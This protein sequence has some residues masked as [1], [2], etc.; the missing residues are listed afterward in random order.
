MPNQLKIFASGNGDVDEMKGQVTVGEIC[1]GVFSEPSRNMG[2]RLAI[3]HIPDTVGGVWRA[4]A[5]VHGKAVAARFKAQEILRVSNI[6]QFSVQTF[7]SALRLPP[8][9]TDYVPSPIDNDSLPIT[10]PPPRIDSL[11][12]RGAITQKPV[13]ASNQ[14]SFLNRSAI[15]LTESPT[16]TGLLSPPNNVTQLSLLTMNT[17]STHTNNNATQL[18]LL[19]MNTGTAAIENFSQRRKDSP[20]LSLLPSPPEN[21]NGN[22]NDNVL[23]GR[24][25]VSSSPETSSLRSSRLGYPTLSP[26]QPFVPRSFQP[27][28]SSS[29]SEEE[30]DDDEEDDDG[31][32][33]DYKPRRHSRISPSINYSEVS[34]HS[35]HDIPDS[36]SIVS[37]TFPRPTTASSSSN[38]NPNPNLTKLSY[39]KPLPPIRTSS[40]EPIS[41]LPYMSPPSPLPP[42]KKIS[43]II[44]STD[45]LL[46][47]DND[48]DDDDSFQVLPRKSKDSLTGITISSLPSPPSSP[49]GFKAPLMTPVPPLPPPQIS[50]QSKPNTQP[51]PPSEPLKVQ[52][53]LPSPQSAQVVQ[54]Q[55]PQADI[56][57]QT[58]SNSQFGFRRLIGSR[59]VEQSQPASPPQN[60]PIE[61]TISHNK[62]PLYGAF[63]SSPNNINNNAKQFTHRRISTSIDEAEERKLAVLEEER[64]RRTM[65]LAERE[66][67]EKREQEARDREFMERR[68]QER[69]KRMEN[70]RRVEMIRVELKRQREEEEARK[71][72]ERERRVEEQLSRQSRDM[73]SP[74]SVL[75]LERIVAIR[76]WDEGYEELEF[77]PNGFAVEMIGGTAWLLFADSKEE[78]E[79]FAGLLGQARCIH[80]Y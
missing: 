52:F 51:S 1:Y 7:R 68:E 4:R 25:H 27:S 34:D 32:A 74:L 77:M 26:R 11:K 49:E 42:L 14:P 19:S 13:P 79:I 15:H 56:Q 17:V 47:I 21:N 28:D 45:R 71:N 12:D 53:K 38:S 59:S 31:D 2:V 8:R 20:P 55:A 69:R 39:D 50:R 58:Q 10:S 6:N 60:P 48:E 44:D 35:D 57:T 73:G 29:S 36:I 3:M 63:R 40:I 37:S 65:E 23:K 64:R 78:K 67:Q 24:E 76:E 54:I 43:L 16:M 46:P 62:L 41:A 9:V 33:C 30:S 61:S 22:G 72:A 5:T 70:V 75:T 66:K 80:P 18:S